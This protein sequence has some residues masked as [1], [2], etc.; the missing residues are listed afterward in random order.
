MNH[1]MIINAKVWMFRCLDGVLL[2]IYAITTEQIALNFCINV[3]LSLES[4][5]G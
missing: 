4:N 2:P 5:K 3:A 1:T